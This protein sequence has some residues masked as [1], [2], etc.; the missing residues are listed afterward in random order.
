MDA[1]LSNQV[2]GYALRIRGT[3]VQSHMGV[4]DS[5]RAVAQELVVAVD[6][7]LPGEAYPMADELGRAADY[8]AVVALADGTARERAYRLLETFAFR[9]ATRLGDH[10]PL[11]ERVRVAVTKAN[12]PVTPRTDEAT[13]EVTLAK[14]LR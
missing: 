2:V 14:G 5:E 13:A 10:F 11:A 9:V 8:A 3:R 1:R 7:E 12:V 4:S 6:V